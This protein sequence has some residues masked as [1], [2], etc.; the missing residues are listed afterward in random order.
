[1]SPLSPEPGG[2]E[3]GLVQPPVMSGPQF[4][5]TH[6]QASL[7][8]GLLAVRRGHNCGRLTGVQG[9]ALMWLAAK[10][11]AT[12]ADTAVCRS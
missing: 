11:T 7:L 10:P 1:M 5:W 12:V 8:S 6:Y 2:L 4:L 3:G 9:E